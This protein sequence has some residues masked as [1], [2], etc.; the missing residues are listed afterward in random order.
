MIW[1]PWNVVTYNDKDQELP[2]PFPGEVSMS[3]QNGD[4]SP[5]LDY[6]I[7]AIIL[8]LHSAYN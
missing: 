1:K 5:I 6:P 3:P 4:V 2:Q 8:W 7:V